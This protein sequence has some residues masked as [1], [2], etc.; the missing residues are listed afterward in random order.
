VIGDRSCLAYAG[1]C[2]D[3]KADT[4]IGVLRRTMLWFAGC[5]VAFERV[6]SDN[7]A[8]QRSLDWRD[9]CTELRIIH[10]CNPTEPAAPLVA[11]HRSPDGP[12][13]LG[14]LAYMRYLDVI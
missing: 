5:G 7:G 11:S 10:F 14:L 4:A 6:L 12:T 1:I 3:K 13:S 8:D 9:A 2:T